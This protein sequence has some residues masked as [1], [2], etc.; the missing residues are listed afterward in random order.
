MKLKR[1]LIF[2]LVILLLSIISIYYPELTGNITN[3]QDNY[4]QKETAILT[5]VVDGD[6]IHV[7]VNGEDW[8]IRMLGINNLKV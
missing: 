7:L 5:R 6:T 4:Y 3:T 2:F 1:I 8:T